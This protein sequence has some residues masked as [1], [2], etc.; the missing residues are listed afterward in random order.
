VLIPLDVLARV[1]TGEVTVAFRSWKRPT[2]K[3]GGTLTTAVGVLAIDA[4]D[5]IDLGSITD[6]DARRSGAADA[7]EVRAWLHDDP[8]RRPHRIAFHLAGPDPRL[9]LRSQAELADDDLVDLTRRLDAMDHRSPTGPWTRSVLDAIAAHPE[10]VS[11]ELAALLGEERDRLKVRIR[12][13]KALGLTE[14]LEVGYRLSPRGRALR[15]RLD[16]A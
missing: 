11:T 7:D 2:V 5:V 14:S 10:V 15:S 16:E 6:E 12:R 3:A 13:L 1:A 8:E 4:V 9:A